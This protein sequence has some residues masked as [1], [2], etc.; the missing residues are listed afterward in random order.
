MR[1]SKKAYAR[2]LNWYKL[3]EPRK[4]MTKSFKKHYAGKRLDVSDGKPGI[5][6]VLLALQKD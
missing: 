4:R 1:N 2:M 6:N 3:N 5:G